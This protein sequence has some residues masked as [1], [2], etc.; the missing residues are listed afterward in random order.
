VRDLSLS[1]TIRVSVGPNGSQANSY[2]A[3]PAINADGR[4]IAFYS[5][6]SNLVANDAN[7][8]LDA[9]VHDRECTG[10]DPSTHFCFG[11]GTG[12]HCPCVNDGAP[13]RGCANSENAN[14]GLFRAAGRPR[15]NPGTG[16]DSIVFGVDGVPARPDALPPGKISVAPVAYGTA[17]AARARSRGSSGSREQPGDRDL[18]EGRPGVGVQRSASQGDPV[19]NSG[20]DALLPGRLPRHGPRVLPGAR[21]GSINITNGLSLVW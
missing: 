3:G 17:C 14:G 21:G 16:T 6:A 20:L 2:S 5:D 9:F 1:T 18:P 11:D 15:R 7:M 12:A 4:H 19:A 8:L 10:P 13:G